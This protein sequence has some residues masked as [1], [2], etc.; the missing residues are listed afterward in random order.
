MNYLSNFLAYLLENYMIIW[1]LLC[2]VSGAYL[3]MVEIPKN[4]ELCKQL[5]VKEKMTF[6]LIVT[7]IILEISGLLA[8]GSI[9][10]YFT[11]K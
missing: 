10:V 4:M 9:I 8:L 6:R 5:N 1:M 11:K 2:G 3:H 7:T